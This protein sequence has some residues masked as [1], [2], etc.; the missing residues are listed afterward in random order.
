MQTKPLPH[1]EASEPRQREGAEAIMFHLDSLHLSDASTELSDVVD[2]DVQV[3]IANGDLGSARVLEEAP[4]EEV[5]RR[6]K[7]VLLS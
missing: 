7:T 5:P 6:S 3:E 4:D 1:P 2:G